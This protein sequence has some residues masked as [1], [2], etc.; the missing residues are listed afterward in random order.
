MKRMEVI[1]IDVFHFCATGDI[2]RTMTTPSGGINE[3]IPVLL[4]S[5]DDEE[6]EDDDR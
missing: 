1:G 2:G 3:H 4:L 5:N 6:E